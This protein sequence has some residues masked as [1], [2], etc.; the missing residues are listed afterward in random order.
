MK[1]VDPKEVSVAEFHGYL[2]STV[3]PRPVA[4]ASTIGRRR[5][6][7][8]SPYSF[9]NAFGSNPP[10]LVFSPNRRVRDNTPKHTYENVKEVAEV[11]INVVDYRWWNRCRWRAASTNG[12]W[13]NS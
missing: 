10:T 3:A 1:T 6:R 12:A 11:V 13:T 8:L 5:T 4:F 2:L 7:N 9:F